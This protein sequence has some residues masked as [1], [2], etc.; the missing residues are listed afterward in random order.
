MLDPNFEIKNSRSLILRED[1]VLY[2]PAHRD[3]HGAY[4]LSAVR[5]GNA[6]R[7]AFNDGTFLLTLGLTAGT[8]LTY[9]PA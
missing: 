2:P 7:I 1:V 9:K 5:L 4:A 8:T 3:G 6:A